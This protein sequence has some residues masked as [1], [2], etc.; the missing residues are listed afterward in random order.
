MP[1]VSV[2]IPVYNTEKYISQCLDSVC[3]QTLKDIEIICINDCSTDS[4]FKIVQDFAQKDSR[5]R[6]IDFPENKGAAAARN[7]GIEAATGEYIGFVDSDDFV[8]LDFYE[9]LY[10]KAKE[11]QTNVVKG[12]LYLYDLVNKKKRIESW[13]D[14][15]DK[16]K[17]HQAYFYFTFTSAIY[18]RQL[19]LENNVRFLDGLI[20][21]EDPYF[22]VKVNLLIDKLYI[23]NDACYYYTDNINSTSR[24]GISLKHIQSTSAGAKEICLLLNHSDIPQ[25][26]YL[27]VFNFVVSQLVYWANKTDCSNEINNCASEALYDIFMLCK[28]QKEC[29]KKYF[30]EKKLWYYKGELLKL[31]EIKSSLV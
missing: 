14:I 15:N 11:I 7:A 31:R 2:I 24:K 19:L 26:H 18:S 22:A 10:T 21:F 9:K 12:K 20:H 1:K 17:K 4:S 29:I 5:I 28:Y 16:I 27:I 13:I 25:E 30:L 23:V 6:L 8:D 3:G